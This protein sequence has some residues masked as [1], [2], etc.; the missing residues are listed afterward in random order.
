MHVSLYS[1][2]MFTILAIEKVRRG[3]KRDSIASG[4]SLSGSTTCWMCTH[5][6]V[7]MLTGSSIG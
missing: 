2:Y 7:V 3:W 1:K 5:L 6:E 4:D